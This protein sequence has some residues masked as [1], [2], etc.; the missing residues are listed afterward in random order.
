MPVLIS[1]QINSKIIAELKPCSD[2]YD[3]WLKHHD[4]FDGDILEF[5][6]LENIPARDKLWV[7][8]RVLPRLLVECFAID[9]AFAA[10]GDAAGDAAVAAER[11]NQVNA[12]IVIIKGGIK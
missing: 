5:L 3:N 4:S 11:E 6:E 9:C 10:A 7:A 2:R 12:L 8:V 1:I